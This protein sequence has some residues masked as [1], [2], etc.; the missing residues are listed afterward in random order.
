MLLIFERG[1]LYAWFVCAGIVVVTQTAR[2]RSADIPDGS[3]R[4]RTSG[5][6]PYGT[7]RQLLP[8]VCCGVSPPDIVSGARGEDPRVLGRIGRKSDRDE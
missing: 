3:T 7:V 6:I 2:L 4:S 5:E 1:R 8:P